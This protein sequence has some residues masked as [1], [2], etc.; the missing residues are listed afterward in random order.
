MSLADKIR[1]KK[2]KPIEG[3][4]IIDN[5]DIKVAAVSHK[6]KPF[7]LGI[8][9]TEERQVE[10]EAAVDIP[11]GGRG[12]YQTQKTLKW[13][14]LYD[15]KVLPDLMPLED[16]KNFATSSVAVTTGSMDVFKATEFKKVKRE[17]LT[18]IENKL[19]TVRG[20]DIL[21]LL[22]EEGFEFEHKKPL[23]GGGTS[24]AGNLRLVRRRK[25]TNSYSNSPPPAST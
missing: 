12:K 15:P 13:K 20:R 23:S 19:T 5:P 25:R 18:G 6:G 3:D 4:M 11:V 14:I 17:K 8:G 2:K 21:E 10:G 1:G 22:R 7:V 9:T 16:F 24:E